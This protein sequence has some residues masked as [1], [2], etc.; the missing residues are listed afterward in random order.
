MIEI[1]TDGSCRKNN[2]G[3]YSIIV[4]NNNEL[5]YAYQCQVDNTTNNQ[6]ELEA[7]ILACKFA[8]TYFPDE[9][10]AIYS[11]S[12]YC[13]NAVNDWMHTWVSKYWLN[14]KNEPVKNQE[15]MKELYSLFSQ[16]FYHCSLYK[17]PGHEDIAGN[18]L[19]DAA[20]CLNKTKFLDIINKKHIK[21]GK[22][23]FPV[24]L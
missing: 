23:D 17:I 14:S 12:A 9:E 2:K 24:K 5:I 6:M 8:D 4:F 13:V 7:I 19:A 3:G 21:I 15:Q 16:D 20:A 10:V 11:D 18:E 1:Y 22:F